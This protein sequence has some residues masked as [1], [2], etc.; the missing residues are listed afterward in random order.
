MRELGRGVGLASEPRD[1]HRVGRPPLAHHLQRDIADR[2]KAAGRGK[3]R[4]SRRGQVRV[5]PRSRAH[6][7]GPVVALQS[8]LQLASMAGRAHATVSR[9]CCTVPQRPEC[10]PH[11]LNGSWLRP[12]WDSNQPAAAWGRATGA[13]RSG[14]SDPLPHKTGRA[15]QGPDLDGHAR[16]IR[17]DQD[18]RLVAL[19]TIGPESARLGR[20][21]VELVT[22]VWT[23]DGQ[24]DTLSAD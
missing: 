9:H 24:G 4:P 20:L 3:P 19:G 22:A 12:G 1:E 5:R 6:R 17:D 23:G 2:A 18:E 14:L 7:N 21:E 8:R 10:L 11:W 13:A 15:T 16:L